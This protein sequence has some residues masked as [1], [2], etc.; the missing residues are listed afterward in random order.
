MKPLQKTLFIFLSFYAFTFYSQT[1]IIYIDFG[2]NNGGA[3]TTAPNWNNITNDKTGAIYNLKN[4]DNV[5][6]GIDI[7]ITD[8]FGGINESGATITTSGYPSTA[9]KDSFFGDTGGI[10]NNS[11]GALEFSNLIVGKTYDI[12]FFASRNGVSDNRET[13]YKVEGANTHTVFL[14]A[15]NN[16]ATKVTTTFS[17]KADGTATISVTAGASNTTTSKYFYLGAI[18]L[19]SSTTTPTTTDN[20]LFID[21]GSPSIQSSAPWNN[22]TDYSIAGKIDNL[23][24]YG[25]TNSGIKLSVIDAFSFYN[26]EG[27]TSAG[28]ATG[29]T[30]TVTND[31]FFGNAATFAESPT[32][33]GTGAIKFENFN[34]L[35]DVTLTIYA[36]RM[37]YTDNYNRETQYEIT[38]ATTE[39]LYFN[40][41]NNTNNSITTTLKPNASGEIVI[42]L[43]P[44]ANNTTPEQFFYIGA[45]KIDYTP[46]P[47]LTLKYPN[48]GEFWQVGKVPA[49]IWDSSSLSADVVLEY[50]TNNGSSWN[51]ITTVSSTTNSYNW[52][53]PNNVSTECKV[54]ITSSGASAISQNVFEISSNNLSCNI[55]VLG[56]STSEGTGASTLANSWVGLFEKEIFQK[57]T[58]LNVINLGKGGYTTY[59]ILP[60]GSTIPS[61]VSVTI[62]EARNITQALSHNPIAI[63]VNMPSNDTANGYPLNDQMNNYAI[64]NTEATNASVPIWMATTQPRNFANSTDIQTQIAVKDAIISTYGTYSIDFWSPI[65]NE[66]GYIL[67]IVDYG[68]GVH[69]NDAGH[70]LLFEKVLDK[71]IHTLSCNASVL[72]VDTILLDENTIKIFPNPTSGHL[73]INFKATDSGELVIEFFDALGRKVL[74]NKSVHYNL[75]ANS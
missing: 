49:I 53:I 14:N 32:V 35:E 7:K 8:D 61:G 1:E 5:S 13:Q 51:P 11:S 29:Y 72:D 42:S 50:S 46:E 21:F 40:A 20:A 37:D 26:T 39:T 23:V 27:T 55:V 75:V 16:T 2:A 58:Q 25:G 69:L 31:S 12:Y 45:L 15:A 63:I 74:N 19:V 47:S 70:Q 36:S 6:T 18:E 66:N 65:A 28:I 30:S 22:L 56:S 44:G 68:D 73:T 10:S 33:D 41:N 4:F 52:T 59:H 34:P 38:G 24:N 62:D 67:S 71:N 54:R 57:N 17:P 9:T 48:G 64:L 60:T 3:S 43:S